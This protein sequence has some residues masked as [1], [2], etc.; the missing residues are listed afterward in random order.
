LWS[1][2][3]LWSVPKN[4]STK[5]KESGGVVHYLSPTFPHQHKIW[6][7]TVNRHSRT[8][9]QYLSRK[10]YP[11]NKPCLIVE[12]RSL[13]SF[14]LNTKIFQFFSEKINFPKKKMKLNERKRNVFVVSLLRFLFWVIDGYIYTEI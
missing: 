8:I 7:K 10:K 6:R 2:I 11:Y 3:K 9:P 13:S 1:L 5:P 14:L 12:K 4:I